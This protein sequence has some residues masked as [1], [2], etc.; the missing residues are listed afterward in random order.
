MQKKKIYAIIAIIA[1]SVLGAVGLEYLTDY[2]FPDINNLGGIIVQLSSTPS[3][4]IKYA[5]KF[6]DCCVLD[7]KVLKWGD[8]EAK[9]IFDSK[10]LENPDPN[11]RGTAAS[12]LCYLKYEPALPQLLELLK[13]DQI[14]IGN[15]LHHFKNK[16]SHEMIKKM[17]SSDPVIRKNIY[18]FIYGSRL[19]D[20][21][22]VLRTL[23]SVLK[24]D[25][26]EDA[27]FFACSALSV[28]ISPL[29]VDALSECM[30]NDKSERVR[31]YCEQTLKHVKHNIEKAETSSTAN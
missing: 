5:C 18:R 25:P 28:S 7:R 24:N 6:S 21:E 31:R 12:I 27:R 3:T 8:K 17:D 30:Q 26:D 22:Y 10:L 9:E 13:D 15:S 14:E 2:L 16:I 19:C 29:T 4:A 1:I 23:L 20:Q 11:I